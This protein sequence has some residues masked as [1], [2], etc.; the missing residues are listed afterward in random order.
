MICLASSTPAR[1]S[2]S[3][4]FLTLAMLIDGDVAFVGFETQVDFVGRATGEFLGVSDGFD[5]YV[6]AVADVG[7]AIGDFGTH[8]FDESLDF[9]GETVQLSHDG[10]EEVYGFREDVFNAEAHGFAVEEFHLQEADLHVDELVNESHFGWCD[11]VELFDEVGSDSEGL[12]VVCDEVI[13]ILHGVEAVL[14]RV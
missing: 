1:G 9:G 8:C 6:V 7:F 2:V 5:F 3:I 10:G 14:E 11:G 4:S 13:E 12:V